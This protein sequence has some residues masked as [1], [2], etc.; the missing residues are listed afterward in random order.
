M[1]GRQTG[2]SV[3]AQHQTQLTWSVVYDGSVSGQAWDPLDWFPF[4]TPGPL[5]GFA[6]PYP[7]LD[8]A[9]FV[10]GRVLPV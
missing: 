7:G 4:G 1:S 5:S 10:R 2:A 9:G 8:V 6:T 3:V